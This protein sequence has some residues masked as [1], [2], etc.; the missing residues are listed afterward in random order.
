MKAF[1][2]EEI[3]L[4]RSFG[5]NEDEKE[6][7]FLNWVN[8]FWRD[9]VLSIPECIWQRFS[10]KF[11]FQIESIHLYFKNQHSQVITLTIICATFMCLNIVQFKISTCGRKF[12][13][14][15][16]LN[17]SFNAKY[18]PRMFNKNGQIIEGAEVCF[19]CWCWCWLRLFLKF[20]SKRITCTVFIK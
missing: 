11:F 12:P 6:L 9:L 2:C 3:V 16:V 20:T 13:H 14:K 5:S 18:C 10:K 1:D 4:E 15:N 8:V 17:T 19:W 7:K